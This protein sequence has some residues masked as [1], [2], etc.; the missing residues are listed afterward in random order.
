VF[1]ITD[2]KARM[3]ELDQK[4]P[5]AMPKKI[6]V[7]GRDFDPAKPDDYIKGFAIKRA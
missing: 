3:K 4:V 7:M 1:L 2:A 6:T 5:N